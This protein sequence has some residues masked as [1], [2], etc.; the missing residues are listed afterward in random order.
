M[1][2]DSAVKELVYNAT[3]RGMSHDE[4]RALLDK[5]EHYGGSCSELPK[6]ELSRDA[7]YDGFHAP[8]RY[9]ITTPGGQYTHVYWQPRRYTREP[10]TDGLW[11]GRATQWDLPR[12]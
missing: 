11:Y 4:G 6:R 5:I 2:S 12:A 3:M 7:Y 9:R 10:D 8:T 1:N